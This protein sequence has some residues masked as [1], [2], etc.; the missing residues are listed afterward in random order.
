[1]SAAREVTVTIEVCT[2]RVEAALRTA[3]AALAPLA[4]QISLAR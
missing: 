1:V 4:W 2:E 3:I